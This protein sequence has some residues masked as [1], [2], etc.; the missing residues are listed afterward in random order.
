MR[1]TQV[2][3][4]VVIGLSVPA[5]A[6]PIT[7][8]D[9]DGN[10]VPNIL[11]AL[12][13]VEIHLGLYLATPAEILRCDVTAPAGVTVLDALRLAQRAAGLAG[14]SSCRCLLRV[15]ESQP[16]ASRAC[17]FPESMSAS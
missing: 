15:D 7:C 5:S 9:C 11:D 6:L 4:I 2:L 8:G 10:G 17:R 14:H 1:A 12:R 13:A 3:I 16:A